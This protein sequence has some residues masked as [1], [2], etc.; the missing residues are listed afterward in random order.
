MKLLLKKYWWLLL[1]IIFV[2][3]FRLFPDKLP[4]LEKIQKPT[5][6]VSDTS[7]NDP[8]SERK[9]TEI[10][11]SQETKFPSPLSA[12]TRTKD[13]ENQ[14]PI[15]DSQKIASVVEAAND[16][17]KSAN[18]KN[19]KARDELMHEFRNYYYEALSSYNSNNNVNNWQY[20]LAD[21]EKRT[22]D[23]S[24]SKAGWSLK[25]SEGMY[26]IGESGGWFEN[27]FELILTDTYRKYLIIRTKE[28]QEGFSEDAG[29]LIS[30]EQLR[31]RISLWEQFLKNHPNFIESSEIKD[32]L[33]LYVRTF[34]TGMDNSR[35]H[36]FNN[37]TLRPDVKTAYEKYIRDNKDSEYY[38]L[39][40]DYYEMLKNNNF[41]VPD[42]INEFVRKKGYETM[43]G[44]QPPTY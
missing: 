7:T 24:L 42:N 30:W 38:I 5:L 37:R 3:I 11:L 20:P 36:D 31:E 4:F 26:Y 14:L 29:L 32:Y 34:L 18:T 35:I 43:L 15:I 22:I 44:K 27:T 40:K 10:N 23:L 19:D 13:F 17:I 1:L 28:I 12:D 39:V 33:N 2:L 21:S 25:E 16:V 6:T 9:K 8:L 41:T